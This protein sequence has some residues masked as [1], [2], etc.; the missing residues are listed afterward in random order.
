MLKPFGP[1]DPDKRG[2][3][4]CTSELVHVS[5]ARISMSVNDRR[6]RCTARDLQGPH[7]IWVKAKKGVYLGPFRGP[8]ARGERRSGS[9]IH[10]GTLQLHTF[11]LTM[12]DCATYRT[13]RWQG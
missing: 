5:A 1:G 2:E 8:L 3:T 9:G 7:W 11:T 4:R 10:L 12:I 13:C 6:Q